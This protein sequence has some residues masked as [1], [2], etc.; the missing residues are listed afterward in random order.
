MTLSDPTLL[1]ELLGSHPPAE[2]LCAP[3]SRK[4]ELTHVSE[5]LALSGIPVAESLKKRMLDEMAALIE[6]EYRSEHE[7]VP[8]RSA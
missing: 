5:I 3:S 7:C 4:N 1:F 6:G 2:R 8:R